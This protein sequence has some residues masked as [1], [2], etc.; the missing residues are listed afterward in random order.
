M[1]VKNVSNPFSTRR[2]LL[3]R[4]SFRAEREIPLPQ[5]RDFSAQKPRLEMTGGVVT[6]KPNHF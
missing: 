5:E 1:R 2:Q 4:V 3:S 6:S